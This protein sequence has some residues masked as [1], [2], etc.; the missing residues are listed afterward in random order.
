[1]AVTAI[2]Y[3]YVSHYSGYT[4]TLR[5]AADYEDVTYT[6]FAVTAPIRQLS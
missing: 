2:E 3:T 4:H 1:M 5:P 6:I